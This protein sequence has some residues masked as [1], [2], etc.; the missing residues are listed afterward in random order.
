[1][2]IIRPKSY[3]NQT[4]FNFTKYSMYNFFQDFDLYTT[5]SEEEYLLDVWKT[6]A[7]NS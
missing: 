2:H 4:I 3:N 1:M 5:S 7:Q 6:A